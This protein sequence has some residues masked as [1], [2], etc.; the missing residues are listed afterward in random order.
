MTRKEECD[1]AV[2]SYLEDPMKENVL[3]LHHLNTLSSNGFERIVRKNINTAIRKAN[4]FDPIT[5]RNQLNILYAIVEQPQ[6][7]YKL[8]QKRI[9]P[10]VFPSNTSIPIL[11]KEIRKV[12][13][14][15]WDEFD[16][17]NCHLAIC[18]TQWNLRKVERILQRN[19]N[20]W[21]VIFHDLCFDYWRMKERAHYRYNRIKDKLK[22][23]MYSLI[24]GMW[25]ENIVTNMNNSFC[26]LTDEHGDTL[27]PGRNIGNEFIEMDY[28]AETLRARNRRLR[29]LKKDRRI[30][31]CFH[32]E[33]EC[34]KKMKVNERSLLA[35][36]L[37]SIEL[38]ILQPVIELSRSSGTNG[39]TIM[40]WQHDGF[41]VC[42]HDKTKREKWRRKIR[43]VV[44][45]RAS[46]FG[47]ELE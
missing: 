40:L 26:E 31:T 5:R 28:I 41:S 47:T 1:E 44:N 20:I 14:K 43:E 24:Y 32:R 4:E 27:F 13:T 6:P 12:L 30:Q 2:N 46:R 10:R 16:L 19:E 21:E 39:F 17:K 37:Q 34:S 11:K 22:D 45:R 29:K 36:E 8:S 3:L 33:I 7:F 38:F 18:A 42:Y 23:G 15:E 9:T 25:K 35:S